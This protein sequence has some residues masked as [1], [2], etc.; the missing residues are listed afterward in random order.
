MILFILI[1]TCLN[2]D[3]KTNDPHLAVSKHSPKLLYA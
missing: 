3:E 1:F 2:R